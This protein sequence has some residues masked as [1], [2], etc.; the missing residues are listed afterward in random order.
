MDS[1][2]RAAYWETQVLTASPQK[3]RLMLIEGALR[4][5]RQVLHFWGEE[6]YDEAFTAM[7]RTQDIIFELLTSVQ[8]NDSELN[9]KIAGVYLFLYQTLVNSQVKR[10][11]Q[12]MEDVLRVLAEER[13][14]W[15]QFCELHPDSPSRDELQKLQPEEITAR[16]SPA[17][18]SSH[19]GPQGHF[20]ANSSTPSTPASASF[21]MDA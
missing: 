18:H 6:N 12:G 19:V 5:G 20:G 3:L 21:S 17:I 2:A 11:R 9:R 15:R 10:D 16:N 8:R 14:T 4:Y 7:M 1:N 13:E